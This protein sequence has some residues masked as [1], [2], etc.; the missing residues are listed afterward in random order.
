MRLRLPAAPRHVQVDCEVVELSADA[1]GTLELPVG[2]HELTVQVADREPEEQT[3][4][5]PAGSTVD[6]TIRLSW[7]PDAQAERRQ[8]AHRRR[9][10]GLIFSGIGAVFLG[11]GVGLVGWNERQIRKTDAAFAELND[12]CDGASP[13]PS[14]FE[15]ALLRRGEALA[16][17]QNHQDLMRAISYTITGV[18]VV[19]T[20]VGLT[21]WLSSPSDA[22]IDEAASA[23]LTLLPGGARF[24]LAF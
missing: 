17:D 2:P 22:E 6:L 3:I 14:C 13:L 5:V 11:A 15:P 18:G 10:V 16:Q 21:L 24:S 9:L 20:A 8:R 4:E 19:S 23:R 7:T 12:M 1:N